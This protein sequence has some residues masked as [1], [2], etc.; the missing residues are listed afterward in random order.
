MQCAS[1]TANSLIGNFESAKSMRPTLTSTRSWPPSKDRQRPFEQPVCN[2]GSLGRYLLAQ[3]G[4]IAVIRDSGHSSFD[5]S[6]P[7][8]LLVARGKQISYHCRNAHSQAKVTDGKWHHIA[9]TIN[10]DAKTAGVS[11]QLFIDGQVADKLIIAGQLGTVGPS[12]T[13]SIEELECYV[14]MRE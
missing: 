5:T 2:D 10:Q 9:V 12:G 1:S 14:Y 3:W 13:V 7:C 4:R 6:P 11:A 8:F